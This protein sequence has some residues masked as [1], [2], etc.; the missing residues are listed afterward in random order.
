MVDG[1]YFCFDYSRLNQKHET[2]VVLWSHETGGIE[3]VAD[4]FAEF[5]DGLEAL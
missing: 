1:D 2:P 4:N 5:V 3:D